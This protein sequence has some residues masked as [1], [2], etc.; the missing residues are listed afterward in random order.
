[1][2]RSLPRGT[3]HDRK[4]PDGHSCNSDREPRSAGLPEDTT[5]GGDSV[6]GH[7]TPSALLTIFPPVLGTQATSSGWDIQRVDWV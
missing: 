2:E 5:R 1:M 6:W 4:S 7:G 3:K